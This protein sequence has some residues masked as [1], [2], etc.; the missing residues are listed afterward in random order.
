VDDRAVTTMV[1]GRRRVGNRAAI[2]LPEWVV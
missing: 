1:Q 2:T